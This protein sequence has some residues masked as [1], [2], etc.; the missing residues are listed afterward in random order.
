M[1]HRMNSSATAWPSSTLPP[2]SSQSTSSLNPT[3]ADKFLQSLNLPDPETALRQL[4]QSRSR[5]EHNKSILQLLQQSLDA[6]E[7]VIPANGNNEQREALLKEL[8]RNIE[9]HT[10]M[11]QR[12]SLRFA[13]KESYVK[14]HLAINNNPVQSTSNRHPSGSQTL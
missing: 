3:D 6:T 14:D 7:K 10:L 5:L 13:V 2:Q 12:E 9:R 8:K 4:D 11:V 1:N